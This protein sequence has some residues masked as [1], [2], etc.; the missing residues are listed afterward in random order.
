MK[1]YFNVLIIALMLF[2]LCSCGKST[3]ELISSK[4]TNEPGGS[5]TISIKCDTL[6]DNMDRLKESKRDFVPEKGIILDTTKVDFFKGA[7]VYDILKQVCE[8][9]NIHMEA[10]YSITFKSSYIEGINQLYEYDAGEKSGWMFSV[11]SKFP[12]YGAS[13]YQ[14]SDGDNIEFVY[15]C[16]LGKDV[17]DNSMK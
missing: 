2:L 4:M 10:S 17:G 15:T 8:E 3:D 13:S 5:C 11:N 6:L 7:S 1:R 9:N 16:D 12:N 14:V